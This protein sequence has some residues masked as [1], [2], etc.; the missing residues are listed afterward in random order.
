MMLHCRLSILLVSQTEFNF[1]LCGSGLVF[2]L[3]QV[4]RRAYKRECAAASERAAL[5][6]NYPDR[7]LGI[8]GTAP[9]RRSCSRSTLHL[10]MHS[11]KRRRIHLDL[12]SMQRQQNEQLSSSAQDK[13]DCFNN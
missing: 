3:L 11:T 10:S 5:D 1:S 9:R 13:H 12:V 6:F 4:A 7:S 8:K 2:N